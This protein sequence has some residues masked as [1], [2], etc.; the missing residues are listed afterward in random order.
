M[1]ESLFVKII[2]SNGKEELFTIGKNNVI[3]LEVDPDIIIYLED[4]GRKYTK[5]INMSNVLNCETNIK[6]KNII[7]PDKLDPFKEPGT[8]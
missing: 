3:N 1:D 4:D 7:Y 2:Y 5:K 8:E 6:V